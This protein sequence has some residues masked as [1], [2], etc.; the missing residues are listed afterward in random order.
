MFNTMDD[1][2]KDIDN[3]NPKRD[4]KVLIVFDDMLQML[5][6]IKDFKA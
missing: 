2:Y 5:Q 1:V 3:Y 4:K 6:K